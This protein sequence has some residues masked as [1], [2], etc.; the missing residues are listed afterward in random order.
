MTEEI[1]NKDR[2]ID[3]GFMQFYLDLECVRDREGPKY[4]TK[5][6]SCADLHA[7]EGSEEDGTVWHE[8]NKCWVLQPGQSACIGT[9]I[10]IKNYERIDNNKET[11]CVV[12]EIQIRPRS[13]LSKRKKTIILGTV[14]MDYRNEIMMNAMNG[15]DQPWIIQPGDRIAQAALT[16][17]IRIPGVLVTDNV[18]E[19][20]FGSTG[21]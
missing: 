9:G 1:Q 19:G 6:S 18:R 10:R 16:L 15:S 12:P 11:M 20:G 8:K 13:G 7:M 4:K 14:D 3:L 5:L 17:T 2:I 21:V